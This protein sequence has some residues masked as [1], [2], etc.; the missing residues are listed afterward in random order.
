MPKP[1]VVI[2]LDSEKQKRDLKMLAIKNGTTVQAMAKPVLL[3]LLKQ[4]P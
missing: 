1:R 3:A 4:K 2:Y